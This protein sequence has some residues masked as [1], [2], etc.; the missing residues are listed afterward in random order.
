MPAYRETGGFLTAQNY[1]VSIYQFAD[2]LKTDRRFVQ[3]QA[4]LSRDPVYQVRGRHA[5]C[6]ALCPAAAL[7]QIICQK[8]DEVVW[9][10]KFAITVDNTKSVAVAICC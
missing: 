10:N 2:V 3:R 9:C 7:G 6:H 1:L 5:S 8:G 4:P